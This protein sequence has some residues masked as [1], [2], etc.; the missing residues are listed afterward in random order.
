M[1]IAD[2]PLV[3]AT[4][5]GASALLLAGGFGAIRARRVG[6]HRALM[7]A[8]FVL[9]IA[10]LACYLVYHAHAGIK[11]F[12]GP[13][14]VRTIYLTILATHTVLAALVP[15]LAIATL[16]RALRG[17][18]P[19]HR[20]LAHWTLPVWGYVSVTGVVIYWMLFG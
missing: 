9:S 16:V 17:R 11:R 7:V 5:N 18:F 19:Q 20:A 12:E 6:L 8:A 13:A 15:F 3:N 4:L 14:T 1:T 2:L 10:F